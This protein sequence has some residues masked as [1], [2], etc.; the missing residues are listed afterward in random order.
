MQ[1]TNSNLSAARSLARVL[2]GNPPTKDLL[3][4]IKKEYIQHRKGHSVIA[5]Q[6]WLKDKLLTLMNSKTTHSTDKGMSDAHTKLAKEIT[7]LD[8]YNTHDSEF[9]LACQHAFQALPNPTTANG[10][11]E[12]SLTSQNRVGQQEIKEE[13][14]KEKGEAVDPAEISAAKKEARTILNKFGGRSTSEIL[15]SLRNQYQDQLSKHYLQMSA[16]CLNGQIPHSSTRLRDLE[17]S[18]SDKLATLMIAKATISDSK[19]GIDVVNKFQ[20]VASDDMYT[21][22]RSIVNKA[23]QKSE[24]F[25]S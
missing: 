24:P 8:R 19:T 18:F 15:F 1:G 12:I 6:N 13:V 20:E 7:K 22:I 21:S 11:S 3:S 17:N 23:V 2:G 5:S 10:G 16:H 25:L 14:T 4:D 9:K